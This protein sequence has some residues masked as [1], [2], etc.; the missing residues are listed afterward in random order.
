MTALPGKGCDWILGVCVVTFDI[1]VGQS[2]TTLVP[3]GILTAQEK[4]DVAFHSFP[5]SMAFGGCSCA[6]PRRM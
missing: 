4:S 3:E 1:N 5:V 6:L 2:M